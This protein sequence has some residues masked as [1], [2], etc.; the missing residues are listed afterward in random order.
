MIYRRKL[1]LLLTRIF[2]QTEDRTRRRKLEDALLFP[3]IIK[4]VKDPDFLHP[5]RGVQR[6]EKPRV[7][8]P[9]RRR[10]HVSATDFRVC[11]NTRLAL[12]EV[13]SQPPPVYTAP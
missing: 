9:E 2:R 4:R 5:P 1:Q 13:K 8:N 3:L 6:V 11:V 12:K 10:L 7:L